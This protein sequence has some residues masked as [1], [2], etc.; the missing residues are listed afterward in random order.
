MLP[1]G[2]ARGA[3]PRAIERSSR[4]KAMDRAFLRPP[5]VV[6]NAMD[7][8][9]L[10]MESKQDETMVKQWLD[11]ACQRAAS[12]AT[13]TDPTNKC[14]PESPRTRTTDALGAQVAA[15]Y[16]QLSY[17]SAA[18]RSRKTKHPGARRIREAAG[19]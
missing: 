6:R 18:G 7:R 16:K 17:P 8:T 9:Q 1:S 14:S 10:G 11:F 12:A 19:Q 3:A 2:S 5:L 13:Q 4:P 15:L